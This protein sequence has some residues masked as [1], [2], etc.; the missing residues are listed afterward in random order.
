MAYRNRNGDH[1]YWN[2]KN[3]YS[4][5]FECHYFFTFPLKN[6]LNWKLKKVSELSVLKMN[7]NETW[8]AFVRQIAFS[9]LPC[10]WHFNFWHVTN[11]TQSKRLACR[12]WRFL[13]YLRNACLAKFGGFLTGLHIINIFES[14]LKQSNNM[15]R[16][17]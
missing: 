8:L 13:R 5:W 6:M 4:S 10:T 7:I 1:F 12:Q 11:G 15:K 16:E 14:I 2:M 9:L 3:I 17:S